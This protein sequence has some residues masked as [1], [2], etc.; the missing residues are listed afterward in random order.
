[1]NIHYNAISGNTSIERFLQFL[2][3]KGLQSVFYFGFEQIFTK[4][5]QKYFSHSLCRYKNEK[6]A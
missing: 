3:H 6:R 1:M 5:I 2:G 4:L